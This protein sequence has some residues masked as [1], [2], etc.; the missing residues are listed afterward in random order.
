MASAKQLTITTT[1]RRIPCLAP[2]Y[3][4]ISATDPRLEFSELRLLLILLY[5]SWVT[6]YELEEIHNHNFLML[7]LSFKTLLQYSLL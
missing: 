3:R 2:G 6:R 5:Y 4:V 1:M 7:D